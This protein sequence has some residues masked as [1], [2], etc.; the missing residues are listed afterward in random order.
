LSI[1]KAAAFSGYPKR[2]SGPLN[3]RRKSLFLGFSD[4]LLVKYEKI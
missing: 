1:K 4:S 2:G 3:S